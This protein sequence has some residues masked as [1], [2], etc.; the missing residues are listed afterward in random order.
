PAPVDARGRAPSREGVPAGVLAPYELV[1]RPPDV[2]RPHD[3][4][5]ELLLQHAVLVDAR[6]VGERVLAD[7]RLVRLDVDARDV[8]EEPR[9]LEDLLGPNARVDA[10]EG[11]AGP[12]RHHDLLERRVARARSDPVA[13]PL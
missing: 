3:L 5:R 12:E 4:V 11:L 7:D 2:R 9:G 13:G 6:L 10:K 1:G 8:R